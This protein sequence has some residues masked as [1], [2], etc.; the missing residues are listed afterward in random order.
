M[1]FASALS[2][3]QTD[4]PAPDEELD[5][6]EPLE[7]DDPLLQG[8]DAGNVEELREEDWPGDNIVR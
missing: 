8:D 4:V 1:L 5:E 2:L 7:P 3:A 6:D